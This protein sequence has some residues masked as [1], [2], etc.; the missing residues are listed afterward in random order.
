MDDSDTAQ[1]SSEGV[2]LMQLVL[3]G[4]DGDRQCSGGLE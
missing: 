4:C 3:D 2:V 1:D